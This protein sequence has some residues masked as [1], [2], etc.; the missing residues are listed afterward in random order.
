MRENVDSER[1]ERET[2]RERQSLS[3]I[4]RENVDSERKERETERETERESV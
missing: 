4:V 1:K 3:E 2:E